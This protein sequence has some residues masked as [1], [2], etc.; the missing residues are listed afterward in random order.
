MKSRG[1]S[2]PSRC[3]RDTLYPQKLALTSP[4]SG[5]RSVGIVRSRA[6]ATE[7]FIVFEFETL[8]F[9]NWIRLFAFKQNTTHVSTLY[10]NRL[11]ILSIIVINYN[12]A[13]QSL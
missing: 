11:F 8:V 13:T 6:K 3:P 5:G 12:T 2:D 1:R 4:S 9:P 7:L 10:R